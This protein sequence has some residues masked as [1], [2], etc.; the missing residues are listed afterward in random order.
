MCLKKFRFIGN[1]LTS[2][3]EELTML[4]NLAHVNLMSNDLQ[5]LPSMPFLSNSAKVLFDENPGI[6]EIPFIFG[7]QQNNIK[8]P[9]FRHY[10]HENDSH[11]WSNMRAGGCFQVASRAHVKL[12]ILQKNPPSLMEQ[13]CRALYRLCYCKQLKENFKRVPRTS[14]SYG[15]R[16]LA[17]GHDAILPR[18]L[19]RKLKQGPRTFC[20]CCLQP[21]FSECF[22]SKAL[23][24]I[25]VNGGQIEPVTV[26]YFCTELCCKSMKI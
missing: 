5:E 18:M 23:A 22:S 12:A 3:P 4:P 13:S 19:K 25:S 14:T 17:Q 26:L 1:R 10:V 9:K 21:I 20:C 24:P 8:S 11:L 6:N 7:C 16:L 2:F 15:K